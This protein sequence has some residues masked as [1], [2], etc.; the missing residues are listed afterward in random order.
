MNLRKSLPNGTRLEGWHDPFSFQDYKQ[1][2]ALAALT[3]REALSRKEK[4][5][6]HPFP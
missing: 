6:C 1:L 5:S 2:Y 3:L 4:G